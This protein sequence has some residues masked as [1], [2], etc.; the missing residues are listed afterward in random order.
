MKT[1]ILF[2]NSLNT[3]RQAMK[4]KDKTNAMNVVRTLLKLPEYSKGH[5]KNEL[6]KLQNK[7]SLGTLNE[8]EAMIA[9]LKTYNYKSC[10]TLNEDKLNKRERITEHNLHKH[11]ASVE[12]KEV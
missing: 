3:G 10:Y 12:T 11:V 7:I 1:K 6:R 2:T 8:N 4:D 9:V 5:G